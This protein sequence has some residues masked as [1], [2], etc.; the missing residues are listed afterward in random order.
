VQHRT[1]HATPKAPSAA[2]GLK[3]NLLGLS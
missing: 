3:R 2:A 1:A